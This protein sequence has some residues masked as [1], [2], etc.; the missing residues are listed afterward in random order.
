[1]TYP[2]FWRVY[3]AAHADPRT[4]ALH[5]LGTLLGVASLATAAATGDWRWLLA[6]PVAGYAF[7]WLGHLIFEHNR[8]AT[9]G[10]PYW[11]FVSD[12]RMLALFLS[13]RLDRELR[14]EE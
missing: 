6:A 4:R 5:Y 13:Q 8:P 7:A 11:S 12:F 10:H 9:F 3:L 2:E 1:M 14:R